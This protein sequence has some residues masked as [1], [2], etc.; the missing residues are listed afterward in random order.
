MNP[1]A[2]VL[3]QFVAC[4]VLILWAGIRLS[5]YGDIIAEKT[6]VGGTWVGLV[7]LASVTS[8]PE[9]VTGASAILIAGAPDIAAGDAIGSC[10]FNLVILAMLDVRNPVPLS[11]RV[12]QGH[13]L[14][15]GF[16]IAQLGFLAFAL[17]AGSRAP[18]LGWVGLHSIGFMALYALA[19]RTLFV[20]E[21][22]RVAGL[23]EAPDAARSRTRMTLGK[24]LLFYSGAAA[25]LVAAASVLPGVAV[26]L[27]NITGLGQTFVGSLF[28][29]V[30]TS[31]PEV[32]V[33]MSAMRIGALDM[34]VANLFGSNLFNVAIVGIDDLLY[35]EGP[36]LAKVSGTHLIAVTSA[37]TMTGIAIIGLTYRA[38]RKRFRLSWD[39]LAIVAVYTLGIVLLARSG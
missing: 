4:S 6:G 22:G 39:A 16:G 15:A 11:A 3:L 25:V 21:R 29:A 32:V 2:A 38:A 20:F 27:S 19:V 23:P 1:T 17:L 34:A 18:G 13:V 30:S 7:M 35:T 31:L 12:H 14:G 26:R 37:M 10:M 9:L 8:L 24:V 28:V 36:L 33:S 5:V